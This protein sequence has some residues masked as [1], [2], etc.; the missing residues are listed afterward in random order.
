MQFRSITTFLALMLLLASGIAMLLFLLP[1]P[2]VLSVDMPKGLNC[3]YFV[4]VRSGWGCARFGSF[5]GQ[6]FLAVVII[7]I[8]LLCASWLR[9]SLGI[10]MRATLSVAWS[11][12][13]GLSG[14]IGLLY[15][16][17]GHARLLYGLLSVL[18]ISASGCGFL[19]V[20]RLTRG[21]LG[22]Y[23]V[24]PEREKQLQ[25]GIAVEIAERN[26]E[27]RSAKRA[28]RQA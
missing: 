10:P 27:A 2:R 17:Q 15:V 3:E 14:L 21:R 19:M 8:G 25:D 23:P 18:S 12:F 5:Y 1:I 22:N 4:A 7:T 20:H 13:L 16:L 11:P 24:D 6:P 28:D 9:Y 26:E